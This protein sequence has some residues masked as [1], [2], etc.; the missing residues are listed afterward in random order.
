MPEYVLFVGV[1]LQEGGVIDE[2]HT[3]LI[4]SQSERTMVLRTGQEITEL[5]VSGFATQVPTVM[6]GNMAGNRYIVQVKV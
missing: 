4:L 1:L 3:Y 2:Y 6:A 5:D